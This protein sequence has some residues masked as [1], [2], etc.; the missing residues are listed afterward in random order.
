MLI[1]DNHASTVRDHLLNAMNYN[2]FTAF[3]WTMKVTVGCDAYAN[4]RQ[5]LQE[6]VQPLRANIPVR[7]KSGGDNIYM[8]VARS[9]ASETFAPLFSLEHAFGLQVQSQQKELARGALKTCTQEAK[10]VENFACKF[11]CGKH[12][13][14]N[15]ELQDTCMLV[16]KTPKRRLR[17]HIRRRFRR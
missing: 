4:T 11:G 8:R 16:P 2:F 7:E 10:V 14:R 15:K 12:S 6:E 17:R 5:Y 1:Y 9:D 13:Q 3:I